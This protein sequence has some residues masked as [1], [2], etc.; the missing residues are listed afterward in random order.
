MAQPGPEKHFVSDKLLTNE[1]KILRNK[2]LVLNYLNEA[3]LIDHLKKAACGIESL[4][5]P[6]SSADKLELRVRPNTTLPTMLPEVLADFANHFIRAGC[7]F[8][9]LSSRTKWNNIAE[10][11]LERP[12]NRVRLNT[13]FPVVICS[14]IPCFLIGH[15]RDD[16]GLSKH[17]SAVFALFASR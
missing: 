14:T 2:N 4:T 17:H 13:L 11:R 15:A 9:R 5:F 8:L 1:L 12:L 7:A 3:T 10:M 6:I 16:Y